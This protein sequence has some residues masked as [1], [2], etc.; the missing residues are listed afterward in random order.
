MALG[1]EPSEFRCLPEEML[2]RLD[3]YPDPVGQLA[4]VF[5]HYGRIRRRREDER[6]WDQVQ[7]ARVPPYTG[8]DEVNA[9]LDRRARE[10]GTTPDEEL[11]RLKKKFR[12]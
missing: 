4:E 5:D 12:D 9:E 2:E 8:L 10:R 3:R 11:D 1:S 6:L 7:K